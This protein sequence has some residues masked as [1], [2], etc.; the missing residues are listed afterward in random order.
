VSVGPPGV[1]T[2]SFGSSEQAPPTALVLAL[3]RDMELLEHHLACDP[4]RPREELIAVLDG[5][6]DVEYACWRAA[7]LFELYGRAMTLV[8]LRERG[9]PALMR[10][11]GAAAASAPDVRFAPEEPR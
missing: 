1:T 3:D 5:F 10:A 11:A 4:G 7:Q 8:V 9:G 2:F 6:P